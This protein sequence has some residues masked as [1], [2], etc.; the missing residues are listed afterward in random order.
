[1]AQEVL[2]RGNMIW[3]ES[4]PGSRLRR[5]WCCRCGA[6]MRDAASGL[7]DPILL[8]VGIMAPLTHY[9]ELCEPRASGCSSPSSPVDP[10][11]FAVSL[12]ANDEYGSD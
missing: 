10:D 7:F 3:G 12:Q 2:Q 9:C 5:C 1:M 6:P 4:I 8:A 11:A